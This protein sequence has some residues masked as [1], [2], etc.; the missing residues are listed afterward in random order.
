M[1]HTNFPFARE[2]RRRKRRHFTHGS[3]V[4][5]EGGGPP[6]LTVYGNVWGVRVT[7]G[8]RH[9]SERNEGK[10]FSNEKTFPLLSPRPLPAPR[11]VPGP[12]P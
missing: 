6:F 5:G 4:K 12:L 3:R 1:P 2:R 11:Q 10:K 9:C 8:G 7:V